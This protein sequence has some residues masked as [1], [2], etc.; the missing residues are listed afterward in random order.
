MLVTRKVLTVTK[1]I[2]SGFHILVR[3]NNFQPKY[4]I[5]N[6]GMLMSKINSV[7]VRCRDFTV[8][9]IQAVRKSEALKL[10]NTWKP[11]MRMKI[12]VQKIPQIDSQG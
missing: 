10:Q 5:T 12:V 4:K 1:S 2:S 6:R 9:C 11:L 3:L 8:P 7:R